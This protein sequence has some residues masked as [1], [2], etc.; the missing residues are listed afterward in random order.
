MAVFLGMGTMI[1]AFRHVGMVAC[2]RERLKILVR[3]PASWSAH[4][5]I[6]APGIPSGPAAFLGFTALKFFSHL[7][8]LERERDGVLEPGGGSDCRCVVVVSNRAK[9]LF[10]SSASVLL[11]LQD[12]GGGF[13]L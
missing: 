2:V 11:L 4:A 5:L 7:M 3:I 8:H 10:S 1:E 12:V 6:T 9:R 13:P